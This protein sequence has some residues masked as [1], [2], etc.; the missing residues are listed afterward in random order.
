M[1]SFSGSPVSWSRSAK[2]GISL[3]QAVSLAIALLVW[4]ET[5]YRGIPYLTH[6]E[7]ELSPQIVWKGLIETV[8]A[9]KNGVPTYYQNALWWVDYHLFSYQGT[10][11]LAFS[12]VTWS[13]GI[14]LLW[15]ALAH[16]LMRMR[17]LNIAFGT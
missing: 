5:S 15:H 11:Q 14:V 2:L 7:W 13:A 6:D 16:N 9:G 17:S 3:I 1:T 8:L 10:L 12:F 4:A